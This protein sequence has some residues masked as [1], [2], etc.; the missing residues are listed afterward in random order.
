MNEELKKLIQ[1]LREKKKKAALGGGLKSIAKQHEGGRLTA[2]ERIERL[3]DPAS[4]VEMNMLAALPEDS[5]KDQY[6]DGVVV[7]YGRIDGRKVASTP[8][9]IW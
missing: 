4:F 5:K 8:K 9:I 2:R 3:L 7:G 1:E 6:G